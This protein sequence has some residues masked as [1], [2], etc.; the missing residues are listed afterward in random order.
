MLDQTMRESL[1]EALLNPEQYQALVVDMC[2]KD[3]LYAE[4]T[5]E[6]NQPL[7]ISATIKVIMSGEFWWIL[8]LR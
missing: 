5:G 8:V 3:G 7:Y 6:H 1:I 4:M 2:M